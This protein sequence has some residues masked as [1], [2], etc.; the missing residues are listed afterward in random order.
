MIEA[1]QQSLGTV[2]RGTFYRV[3]SLNESVSRWGI[4]ICNNEN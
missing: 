1:Q 3:G 4:R 2:I